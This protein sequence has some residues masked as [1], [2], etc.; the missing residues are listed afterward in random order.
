MPI[1]DQVVLADRNKLREFTIQ[2]ICLPRPL[3]QSEDARRKLNAIIYAAL[4]AVPALKVP[5][6]NPTR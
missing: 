6:E 4:D 3:L 5:H 1:E 2:V